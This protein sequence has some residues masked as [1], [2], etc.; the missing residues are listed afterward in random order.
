[1][2][3]EEDVQPV[4]SLRE[5]SYTTLIATLRRQRQEDF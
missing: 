3:T 5:K 4:P 1:M 2:I